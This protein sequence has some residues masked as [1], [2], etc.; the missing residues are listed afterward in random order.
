MSTFEARA[1]SLTA[2]EQAEAFLAEHPDCVLFKAGGCRRTDD[3]LE[4]L[5]P[6]FDPRPDVPV[7]IIRVIDARAASRRVAELT[8]VR[9]E[10]PQVLL[11]RARKVVLALD[12]WRIDP[13]ALSRAMEEHFGKAP[14]Q[15]R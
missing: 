14:P 5:R 11:V 15:A 3:A 10:S 4:I 1:L 8:G 7:A 12:N 13:E 2:P 6:L 9:H